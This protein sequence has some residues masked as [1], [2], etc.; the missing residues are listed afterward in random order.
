MLHIF[1]LPDEKEIEVDRGKN[2]LR[3]SIESGIPHTQVC[4]G[5]GRCSTCR[6]MIVEGLEH[7]SER[8][9]KERV[10]AEKLCFDPSIRLACQT[11]VYG[12]VKLR[13]L[14]I[15]KEDAELT[16]QL[17]AGTQSRSVGEE[18]QIAILFADI[19]GFTSFAEKMPAYDVIH[20]LNRYFYQIGKVIARNGGCIDNY[21]GDGFMA[22]FGVEDVDEAPL[23][24]VR[25]GLEMLDTVEELN[26]YLEPLYRWRMKIGIGIHYGEVV[27][28]TIGASG[29]ERRT[30]IGDAVNFASRIESANKELGT[31][32]IIS[33]DLHQLVGDRVMVKNHFQIDI[34][35]KTGKYN[36]YEI[37][38]SSITGSS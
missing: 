4:G 2:I 17:K 9:E 11:D 13:R 7:C 16:S 32:L 38:G 20:V 33:E 34:K 31:E 21:M 35:G 30:V 25:A 1:Y 36:L 10:L 15:D 27:L 8:S 24:S 23:R 26:L 12:D 19:R 14:V 29:N 18:K 6:V 28:G 3:A 5:H 37:T 22:L